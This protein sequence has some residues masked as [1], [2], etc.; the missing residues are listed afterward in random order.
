M[1][2][3]LHLFE[4]DELVEVQSDAGSINQTGK[5]Q[6]IA[7]SLINGAM[8][9]L[10]YET[11]DYGEIIQEPCGCGI[12]GRRIK[13][14]SGRLIRNLK[15]PN[16]T[17]LSPTYF[18]KL[19]KI[20]PLKEFRLTQTSNDTLLVEIEYLDQISEANCHPKR[21]LDYFQN[22]LNDLLKIEIQV[23]KFDYSLKFQRFPS[24]L[25]GT[26]NIDK[27]HIK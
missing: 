18:K 1:H 10:R 16:N 11:G 21:I 24:Y 2:G 7:T 12:P 17:E 14:L 27:C 19:Q 26:N 4:H 22:E 9:L 5:G 13:N 6:I 20:F 3:G 15:L 25:M 23:V 8:P